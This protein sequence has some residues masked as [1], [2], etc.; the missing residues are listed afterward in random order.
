MGILNRDLRRSTASTVIVS[1]VG[2]R[3]SLGPL[4]VDSTSVNRLAVPDRRTKHK[5]ALRIAEQHRLRTSRSR[6]PPRLGDLGTQQRQTLKDRPR[7]SRVR[8]S[9]PVRTLTRFDIRERPHPG[10]STRSLFFP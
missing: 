7:D 10:Y 4:N 1:P 6:H 3:R 2:A 8:V 9:V 5:S